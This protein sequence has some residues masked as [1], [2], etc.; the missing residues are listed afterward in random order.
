MFFVEDF[1]EVAPS[2]FILGRGA[3]TI[4]L[5]YISNAVLAR[6]KAKVSIFLAGYWCYAQGSD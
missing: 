6:R 3:E 2:P 4:P 5:K 1:E